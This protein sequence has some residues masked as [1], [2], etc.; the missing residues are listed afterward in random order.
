ME[1]WQGDR[2]PARLRRR[3]RTLGLSQT[4][5]GALFCRSRTMVFE[6]ET[7]RLPPPSEV[8]A[9]LEQVESG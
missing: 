2:L 5:L 8:V 9:W 4:E 7:G 1:R 6:W 3:R